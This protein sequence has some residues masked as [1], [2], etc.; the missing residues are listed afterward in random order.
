MS[1]PPRNWATSRILVGRSHELDQL[2][3]AL[4]V[5]RAGAGS[6]VLIAGQTGVGK[7][8][9]LAELSASCDC[10]VIE[11]RCYEED[12]A[13]PLAPLAGMLRSLLALSDD[14]YVTDLVRARAADLAFLAP[15]WPH[16][17]Q[18]ATSV[19][20]LDPQANQ[21][22][23]FEAL[24][25]LLAE[26]A[27]RQPL[28]LALEDLHWSDESTLEFVGFL[29]RQIA[30]QRILVVGTY[31][32][33]EASAPLL[34][35]LNQL[36]RRQLGQEIVLRPLTAADVSVLLRTIFAEPPA[37]RPEF[38]ELV[39][40]FSEG[41]PYYAEELLRTLMEAGDIYFDA[42]NGMWERKNITE[43]RVPRGIQETVQ[44]RAAQVSTPAREA[45]TLAAVSGKEFDFALLQQLTGLDEPALLAALKELVA[46]DLIAE[47]SADAFAFRHSLTRQAIRAM[48]LGRERQALHRRV[49]EALER[50][51][52][53]EIDAHDAELAY[54]FYEGQLWQQAMVYAAR[55]G[56]RAMALGATREAL[57]HT[58]R[59]LACAAE[60]GQ[61]PP[62]ELVLRSAQL[63]ETVGDFDTANTL[64]A[65]ALERAHA[66]GDLRVRWQ[67]ML[68]LGFLWTS[69]DY[70]TSQTWFG[71]ALSLA[72]EL[73]EPL[74]LAR[75]L[76]RIGNVY[77]NRDRPD[78]AL[79]YHQQAL[80]IFEAQDDQHGQAETLELLAVTH[81]NLADVLAGADFDERS[82]AL[83]QQ[84]GDQ[85]AAFHASIHLLLPLRMET[86]VGPPVD[87]QRLEALG[88]AA[89][90]TA[91]EM[92][93]PGGEAQA[94]SLLGDLYG[95]LGRYD[96]ALPMLTGGLELATRDQ[97][98]A[99]MAAGER[100]LASILSDLLALDEARERLAR[101][102][103]LADEAGARLFG[104][105]AAQTLA[106]ACIADGSQAALH[107]AATLL[108]AAKNA[109][110]LPQSRF[111]REAMLT[112]AELALATG[113]P[114]EALRAVD[115]LLAST[116]HL[117][118]AGLPAVPRLALLR[119]AS[120]LALG[121][122]TE[123]EA[124]LQAARIGADQQNR[125]P[126]LWRVDVSLGR[127]SLA[128]R[129]RAEAERYFEQARTVIEALASSVPDQAVGQ[130]FRRGALAKIPKI[131]APTARQAAKK[132]YGGLTAREQSVAALVARGLSNREIGA[133][134][135]ISERTVEHHVANILGKLSFTSRAQIA[136][137]AV[138]I[139]LAT[140][141]QSGHLDQ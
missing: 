53:A 120:L 65:K 52:A 64:L 56:D 49:G 62:F 68:Q 118:A 105:I 17:S 139:R 5:A 19:A 114:A 2:R 1:R 48:L 87:P 100:L 12:A 112:Q 61:P 8:R 103:V 70:E 23:L 42:T 10:L 109:D 44:R 84:I 34:K 124:A 14:A 115:E 24:T 88:L 85:R 43:L 127:A 16:L 102:I 93:W 113:Q 128:A 135:V 77:L 26:L 117:Q 13:I 39:Y 92:G 111:S 123:A 141:G 50:I 20:L 25:D 45:L 81:Y 15:G 89:L 60:L 30:S 129:R 137:W 99:G 59:V 71:R 138:E 136:V 6:T 58:S 91:R 125:R 95:L 86:E 76:N 79:A 66:A 55:A 7:S 29:A 134:L 35:L 82:L 46:A 3:A 67:A 18:T 140:P 108:A 97:Q 107:E 27:A 38:I 4:A 72:Q 11:G 104:N 63:H 122:L 119:G 74:A 22:R 116:N 54:H 73:D 106:A 75:T 40:G 126:L 47:T 80:T 37:I 101:A 51:Y 57:V 41:N 69:R 32:P 94:L 90:H 9:L 33:D 132:I 130:Q 110:H 36:R 31:C 98:T 83:A 133:A 96:L 131:P 28:L 121:Q 78:H 21:R